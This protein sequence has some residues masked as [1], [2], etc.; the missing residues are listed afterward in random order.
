MEAYRRAVELANDLHSR[1]MRWT[2]PDQA[3][4][5][6]QL[7]RAADSV[8]ANIAEA[9]GRWHTA[10]KR[11]FLFIARGSLYELEHWMLLAEHR[12]LLELGTS[13]RVDPVARALNGLIK[14]PSPPRTANRNRQP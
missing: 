4:L 13:A 11:R 6:W 14:R 7:S 10:D 5:G 3:N 12:G 8:G 2:R 1:V 9:A